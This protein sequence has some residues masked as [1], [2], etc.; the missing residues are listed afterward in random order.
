M[1]A[2]KSVLEQANAK[3]GKLTA[4]PLGLVQMYI[5][6]SSFYLGC[7]SSKAID[8]SYIVAEIF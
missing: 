6:T 4:N 3:G 8:I 7:D 2:D 5:H 1:A